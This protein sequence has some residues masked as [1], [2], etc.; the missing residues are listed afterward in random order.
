MQQ[1]QAREQFT[2]ET[3][4]DRPKIREI[5]IW[6]RVSLRTV[7]GWARAGKIPCR[8]LGRTYIFDKAALLKWARPEEAA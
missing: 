4:P 3:L 2:D 6:L 1:Q 7:Y 8:K 5:A